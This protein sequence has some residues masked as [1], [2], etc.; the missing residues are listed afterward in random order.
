[1]FSI[2][3]VHYKCSWWKTKKSRL[4]RHIDTRDL[5]QGNET[6]LS[7]YRDG[8]PVEEITDIMSDELSWFAKDLN[9]TPSIVETW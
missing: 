2:P 7:D 6:I 4:L 8:N 5:T 1:M 9:C 3:L